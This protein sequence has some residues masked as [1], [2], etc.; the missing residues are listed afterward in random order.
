M[1]LL[2]AILAPFALCGVAAIALSTA[3][4]MPLAQPSTLASVHAGAMS[5]RRDGLPELSRFQARDGAWLAYRFYAAEGADPWRI[6]ILEH[7]SS[8]SSEE[9]NAVALA[10]AKAGIA[11]VAVDNRGH[12]A[13]GSRGDIGYLGQLDDDLADLLASLKKQHPGSKFLL[14]GHSAGGGFVARVAAGPLAGEF[15]RF[16]LLAPYL[17]YHAPT[18]R[19]ND[20]VGKWVAVDM[21]RVLALSLMERAGVD[22]AQ[23][24]PVLGFAIAP[25][26]IPYVTPSYSY[27]LMRSYASTD[28]WRAPF[29]R[30]GPRISVIAGANDEL[31]N[32]EAYGPSLSP[33]G[34]EVKIVPDVDHMGI[35]YKPAALAALVEAVK[36]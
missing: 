24:L 28:D 7:G 31:M 32:A 23:S 9:M 10:L 29:V 13:S 30:S 19:P 5:I 16:V 8:A 22:W 14:I 36:S 15:E 21:P 26:A 20:G 25:E 11:A 27:R 2:P 3:L 12:G 6:A 1:S 4:A 34:A 17:G 35:V 33:F 18:N